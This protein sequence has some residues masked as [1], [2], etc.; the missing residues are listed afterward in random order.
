MDN[1][2]PIVLWALPTDLCLGICE[3]LP[4]YAIVQFTSCDLILNSLRRKIVFTDE[5][6][7]AKISACLILTV[8]QTYLYLQ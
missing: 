2:N 6:P 5:H 1:L 8:F 3:F 7:Y 4:D